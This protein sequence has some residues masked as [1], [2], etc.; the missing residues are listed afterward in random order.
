MKL[1]IYIYIYMN[2]YGRILDWRLS[3][4]GFDHSFGNLACLTTLKSCD[5]TKQSVCGWLYIYILIATSHMCICVCVWVWIYVHSLSNKSSLWMHLYLCLF[6]VY[7]HIYIYTCSILL[8]T[9]LCN[10]EQVLA[11]TPHKA[12]TIRSPASHHENYPS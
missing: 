3:Q 2:I 4:P 9:F 11:A 10:V 1:Y 5:I 12:P 6:H 7:I 8:A